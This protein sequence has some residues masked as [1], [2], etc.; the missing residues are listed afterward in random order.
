[1]ATEHETMT[2]VAKDNHSAELRSLDV[3]KTK[4]ER[5]HLDMAQRKQSQHDRDIQLK[6]DEM[7]AAFNNYKE[8]MKTKDDV[9]NQAWDDH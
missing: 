3:E 8:Q 9:M 6:E 2:R 7:R 5:E 1:M 4:R